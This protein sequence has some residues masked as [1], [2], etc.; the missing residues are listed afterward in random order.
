MYVENNDYEKRGEHYY[1][2]RVRKERIKRHRVPN[3]I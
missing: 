1:K 2:I 3:K